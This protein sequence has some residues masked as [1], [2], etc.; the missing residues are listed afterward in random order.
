MDKEKLKHTT[1]L[2][3]DKIKQYAVRFG[4]WVWAVSYVCWGI[5]KTCFAILVRR[6]KIRCEFMS[7]GKEAYSQWK[8]GQY[9]SLKEKLNTI[10]VIE[11]EINE[12]SVILRNAYEK[13]LNLC[14]LKSF[15]VKL[16]LRKLKQQPTEPTTQS[17]DKQEPSKTSEKKP[18]LKTAEKPSKSPAKK[19]TA[20]KPP[21][22]KSNSTTTAPKPQGAGTGAKKTSSR[23]PKAKPAIPRKTQKKTPPKPTPEKP[24][25]K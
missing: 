11:E 12:R 5:C 22:Q 17:T 24:E 3:W 4:K 19:T 15:V 1:T 23:T 21:A 9:F 25:S 20:K 14:G 2:I 8:E 13:F 7:F 6:V 18:D 16:R 10:K